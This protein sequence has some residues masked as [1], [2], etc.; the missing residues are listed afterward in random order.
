[1]KDLN[2]E[3]DTTRVNAIIKLEKEGYSTSQIIANCFQNIKVDYYSAKQKKPIQKR[4]FL[5]ATSLYYQ[6]EEDFPGDMCGDGTIFLY[7][8]I[9]FRGKHYIKRLKAAAD[10]D[11]VVIFDYPDFENDFKKHIQYMQ[12]YLTTSAIILDTNTYLEQRILDFITE[13]NFKIT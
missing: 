13:Q 5:G 10:F 8:L 1:M 2:A 4:L 6:L 7:N 3:K 9:H 12:D 11:G